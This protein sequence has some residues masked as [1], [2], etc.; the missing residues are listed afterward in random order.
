MAKFQVTACKLPLRR[1][2]SAAP[3]FL[4][5]RSQLSQ[6]VVVSA[7]LMLCWLKAIDR[8]STCLYVN[9]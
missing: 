7:L 6:G 1:H 8:S 3:D 5:V 4:P 9:V 2:I